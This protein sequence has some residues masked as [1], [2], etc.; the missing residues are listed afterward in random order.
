[1]GPESRTDPQVTPVTQPPCPPT[2]PTWPDPSRGS[3]RYVRPSS[4]LERSSDDCG[5]KHSDRTRFECECSE[6]T[7]LQHQYEK[8]EREVS[9]QKGKINK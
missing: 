8:R 5:A 7:I 1:M 4:P 3:C 9:D 2:E 6:V